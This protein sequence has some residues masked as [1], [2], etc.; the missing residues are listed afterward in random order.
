MSKERQYPP[1][2]KAVFLEKPR[3]RLLMREVKTPVPGPGEVLVR[4][5]AAPVNPSDIAGL[6]RADAEYDLSTFIP[7][8]EGSGIVVAAGKGIIPHLWMGKRVACSSE[9]PSSGTWAEFMVTKAG[10]CFP[11]NSKVDDEQGSMSLVNPLTA[12]AFFEIIKQDRHKAV[13]NNAAAS[14]LGRMIELLGVKFNIPVINIVRTRSQMEM[15]KNDGSRYFLDSSDPLF[16]DDLRKLSDE[17]KATILFDS[18]CSRQ[19]EKMIDVLPPASS[20]IIYGNLSGEE[21]IMINPRS[22][23]DNDIKISGFYLGKRTKENGVIKNMLNLIEVRRLMSADLKIKIQGRF[24]LN[25]S[26]EAVD[27]YLG[28]KS[29]GKVLL[30][31]D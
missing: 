15:L 29:A 8:L 28:N 22:L 16:L 1:V 19:L 3:G 23:I 27:T 21:Q 10:M 7:G 13:I 5:K 14:A 31:M 6:K 12:L 20:V 25:M 24:P 30:V 2:M 26:Q 9:Y 11:L 18:V 4:M 17:L